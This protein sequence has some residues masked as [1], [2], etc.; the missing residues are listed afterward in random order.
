MVTYWNPS[1][2]V[3]L[4]RAN[5]WT[6]TQTFT[7][8][9]SAVVINV[10]GLVVNGASA[11][12]SSIFS[13]NSAVS[14]QSL[15]ITANDSTTFLVG[16]KI[17]ISTDESLSSVWT[18]QNV[19]AS[20][21]T[22]DNF[23]NKGN[24][25]QFTVETFGTTTFKVGDGASNPNFVGT[26]NNTLDSGTGDSSFTGYVKRKGTILNVVTKT[27]T[28][29]AAANDDI[30]IADAT[31]GAFTVTLPAANAQ[32]GQRLTIIK[33]DAGVNAITVS[34]AGADTIEGAASQSLPTQYK[35]T[36]LVSDGSSVWY[37]LGA[38]LV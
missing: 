24:G 20:S 10:G 6:K 1:F 37:D 5:T 7:A 33:K 38:G 13:G 14:A 31:G 34:R 11:N 2:Q 15:N 35:K 29:T 16:N 28:Y 36:T 8:S 3:L 27:T 26:L 19:S 12:N 25:D 18:Y 17:Q 23:L 21:V 9:D 30:I 32:T 22:I 4:N